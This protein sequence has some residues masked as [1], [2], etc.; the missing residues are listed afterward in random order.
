[1]STLAKTSH[2]TAFR[3]N[4]SWL[5]RL[6]FGAVLGQ[7]VVISIVSWGFDVKLPLVQLG[8]VLG[9]ELLFNTWALRLL[10]SHA[11]IGERHITL[12]VGVDLLL[13][14][15]LFYQPRPRQRLRQHLR[16]RAQAG[17][18]SPEFATQTREVSAEQ[19]VGS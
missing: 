18:S 7:L 12:G 10:A 11:P 8:V 6:R 17:S 3:I 14:S 5:L 1:M 9:L 16:S 15:A 13:F 2:D 4:F 19:V